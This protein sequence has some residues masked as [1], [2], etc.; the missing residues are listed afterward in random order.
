MGPERAAAL[1]E[2]LQ[3]LVEESTGEEGPSHARTGDAS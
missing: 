3:I 1:L 2:G